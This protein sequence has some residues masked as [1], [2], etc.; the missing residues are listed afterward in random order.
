MMDNRLL[1]NGRLA[2]TNNKTSSRPLEVIDNEDNITRNDYYQLGSEVTGPAFNTFV[3]QTGAQYNLNEF[4]S[5]LFDAN[6]TNVTGQG[7]S[8]DRVVQLR[9]VFRF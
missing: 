6:F 7:Y 1:L 9:Y 8:N 5:I 3:I 4:H 2:I